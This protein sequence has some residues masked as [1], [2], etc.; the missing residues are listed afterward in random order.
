MRSF[1]RTV[2]SLARSSKST[3]AVT[4]VSGWT[5]SRN[6]RGY[7][8]TKARSAMHRHSRS[9][10]TS[11]AR[12]SLRLALT[13]GAVSSTN[14]S[15]SGVVGASPNRAENRP[16]ARIGSRTARSASCA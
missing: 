8:R 4:T 7:V 15:S 14:A 11:L 6:A 1:S 12:T 13:I 5:A 16:V 2:G 10:P 9:E 3:S